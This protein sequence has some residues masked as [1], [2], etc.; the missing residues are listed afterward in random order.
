MAAAATLI[1]TVT[2][3]IHIVI[4]GYNKSVNIVTGRKRKSTTADVNSEYAVMENKTAATDEEKRSDARSDT[5]RTKKMRMPS[6]KDPKIRFKSRFRSGYGYLSNFYPDV[7][8]RQREPILGPNPARKDGV[9]F[10]CDQKMEWKSSEHYYQYHKYIRLCPALAEAIRSA[11]TALAAK[12]LTS[13]DG[14]CKWV[15]EIN[16]GKKSKKY[17]KEEI[18]RWKGSDRS[19]DIMRR[20]LRFKFSSQN[21][22]LLNALVETYPA[23]L[24]EMGRMKNEFWADTGA[25]MLGL[26]LEEIRREEWERR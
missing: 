25:N 9:L 5:G 6:V 21:P 22:E 10:V 24:S 14:Y 18:K 15:I 8:D 3:M 20:A 7:A 23:R 16:G 13:Q 1:P 17:Y 12:Q 2:G 4:F 19:V 11:P 26:L